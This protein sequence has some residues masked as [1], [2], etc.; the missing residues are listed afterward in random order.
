MQ[1]RAPNT[2]SAKG[3]TPLGSA[4]CIRVGASGARTDA[5]GRYDVVFAGPAT[6]AGPKHFIGTAGLDKLAGREAA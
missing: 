2:V 4:E 3:Y 6:W 1:V 5:T